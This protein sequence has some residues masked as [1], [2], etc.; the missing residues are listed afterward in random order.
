M[1]KCCNIIKIRKKFWTKLKFLYK[2]FIFQ[3]IIIVYRYKYNIYLH[4]MEEIG[5]EYIK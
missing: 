2:T 4:I 3:Q 1:D 5:N